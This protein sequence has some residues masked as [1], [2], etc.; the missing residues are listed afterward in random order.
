MRLLPQ[1]AVQRFASDLAAL[2]PAPSADRPLGVAV[3]G[4]PDSMALL[5]L[6]HAAFPGAVAAATVDHRLRA[7]AA[8]EAATVAR[9][10]AGAG[11]A[12]AILPADEDLRGA[13]L[14][15][16]ARALRYRL[17]EQWAEQAGAA[18]IA[19]AHHADDQAETFLMRAVRGSG[20]AGLAGIRAVRAGDGSGRPIVRPLLGWRRADLRALVTDAAIPF[21]DDPSNRD[22][23]FERVRVRRL[24][25][26][27]P[28]LDADGLARAARHAAEAEGA[29]AQTARWL[30]AARAV[31]PPAEQAY[32]LWLDMAD[33]PRE[34]QRR[35]VR[36]AIGEVRLASGHAPFDPGTN[37]ESLLDALNAG[38][39][40][41]QGPVLV[42]PRGTIWRFSEAPPRRSH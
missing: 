4:G 39:A 12:H 1:A 35:L 32:E 3:S 22:A 29:L 41:T 5:A 27:Q 38:T 2:F 34:V 17:L 30:R 26:E 15:A 9:W 19:T 25:A 16:R 42:R 18:A 20:P 10:C 33:L 11:V 24:L 14:Q 28:W 6:A 7:A 31:S 37:I 13:D 23:A 21:A 36:L 40:A 8:E